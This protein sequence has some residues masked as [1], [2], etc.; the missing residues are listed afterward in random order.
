MSQQQEFSRNDPAV[1]RITTL[2]PKVEQSW[3]GLGPQLSKTPPSASPI[4]TAVSLRCLQ[5]R[6]AATARQSETIETPLQLVR[7]A[8]IKT[9]LGTVRMRPSSRKMQRIEQSATMSWVS[10]DPFKRRPRTLF[11]KLGLIEQLSCATPLPELTSNEFKGL[12]SSFELPDF[13]EEDDF[14][15]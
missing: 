12:L 10:T 14:S 11:E 5:P 8:K 15:N 1:S 2:R 7:W 4:M 9:Q 6:Q 13:K 3:Q